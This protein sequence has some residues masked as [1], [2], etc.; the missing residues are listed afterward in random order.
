MSVSSDDL[1]AAHALLDGR[2][3]RDE[4]LAERAVS[5]LCDALAGRPV[6][7]LATLEAGNT[8]K[9]LGSLVTQRRFALAARLGAAAG[10][11]FTSA[12][13]LH[14]CWA[15]AC[16]DSGDLDRAQ[17]VLTDALSATAASDPERFELLGL[18]GRWHKQRFVMHGDPVDL[19]AS[20]ARYA[21]TY[22]QGQG[23]LYWHGINAVAL[24]SMA[25]RVGVLLT[26]ELDDQALARRLLK[27][28][29]ADFRKGRAD[30]WSH[31]TAA[32]AALALD[33]W[34]DAELWLYRY[35][36]DE[37]AS[38]FAL[39][40][41]ARQ[42][43]EI[44]GLK[45]EL[46]EAGRLLL[47]L[48]RALA[49]RG[50][51]LQ[52]EAGQ[53]EAQA[54]T[55]HAY[56]ERVFGKERFFGYDRWRKALDSCEAVARIERV[57]GVGVGTGFLLA[58][59][60]LHPSFGAAPVLVTNAHVISP[61]GVPDALHPDEARVRFEVDAR[62]TPGYAP[63]SVAE[64]LYSSPPAEIGD[65]SRPDDGFDVTI[66]RLQGTTLPTRTLQ[67]AK[68]LPVL[69][70]SVRA[71]V[72]GHPDG[73]GLQFS[74]GDNEVLDQDEAGKLVHYRTPTVGGSSGSP[75]FNADWA[76]FAL[77]HAGSDTTPRLHG[78]GSYQANEGIALPAIVAALKAKFG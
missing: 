10:P 3:P 52:V 48:E 69:D 29:T 4:R 66:V 19:A 50:G 15:Q 53:L 68:R 58:G 27:E 26:G 55:P 74:I 40:S 13:K 14:R 16:I 25:R 17:S 51:A 39:A 67:P 35:V 11:V 78:S 8:T 56:L 61:D 76:V 64:V 72:V 62:R 60:A 36:N 38:P 2:V 23:R 59:Q 77:H 43:R 57:S 65:I 6:P 45:R 33:K 49:Q 21:D 71:Y 47:I 70:A 18:Q 42:F 22:N 5:L 37:G 34:Q 32:E 28:R 7:A 1:S 20:V 24:A 44:W 73:D 31:A 9:A 63:L 75:V 54:A 12:S 46:G 41:T 30:A